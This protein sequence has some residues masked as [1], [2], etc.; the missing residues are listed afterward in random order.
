MTDPVIIISLFVVADIISFVWMCWSLM[1]LVICW[2]TDKFSFDNVYFAYSCY[3]SNLWWG[4]HRSQVVAFLRALSIGRPRLV[5]QPSIILAT[6]PRRKSLRKTDFVIQQQTFI[7]S[8]IPDAN[9]STFAVLSQQFDF[10]HSSE[11][12]YSSGSLRHSLSSTL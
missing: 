9:T 10:H 2:E 8:K 11:Q 3:P 4:V 5:I 6:L 12:S 1:D 7:R